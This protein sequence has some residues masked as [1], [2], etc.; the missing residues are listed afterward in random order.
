MNKI[1]L[2]ILYNKFNK[3]LFISVSFLLFIFLSL[4]SLYTSFIF[5]INNS[6][7]DLLLLK[8]YIF[9]MQSNT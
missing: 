7:K 1:L 3:K 9:D 2:F 8:E 4:L 6:K 5:S